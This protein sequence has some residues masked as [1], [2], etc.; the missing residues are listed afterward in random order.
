MTETRP[1]SQRVPAWSPSRHSSSQRATCRGNWPCYLSRERSHRALRPGSGRRQKIHEVCPARRVGAWTLCDARHEKARRTRSS[2]LLIGRSWNGTRF[3]SQRARRATPS[4]AGSR[5]RRSVRKNVDLK[6]CKRFHSFL[7]RLTHSRQL[8]K[9][10]PSH[11]DAWLF[12]EIRGVHCKHLGQ[13]SHY[14]GF[15]C[16]DRSARCGGD[17]DG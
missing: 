8:A 7:P 17:W 9:P 16:K 13:R 14:C 10:K 2:L 1:M 15:R 4:R 6:C 5:A 12:T 3:S 11:F